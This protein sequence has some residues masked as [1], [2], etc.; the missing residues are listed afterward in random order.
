MIYT[1]AT[2]LPYCNN[3]SCKERHFN[4]VDYMISKVMIFLKKKKGGG[5]GFDHMTLSFSLLSHAH[6]LQPD[7]YRETTYLYSFA[8][9][10]SK[11]SF[12]RLIISRILDSD[13]IYCN[14]YNNGIYSQK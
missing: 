11:Y 9:V 8:I 5:G 12:I 6:T 2:P 10:L 3:L 1:C 7:I 4:Y 13:N 14:I